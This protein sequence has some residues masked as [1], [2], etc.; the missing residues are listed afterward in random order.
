VALSV[1]LNS[2]ARFP[3]TVGINVTE[4]WQEPPTGSA[5][6]QLL[7]SEKSP[8]YEICKMLIREA[9]VLLNVTT[10]GVEIVPTT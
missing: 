7:V 2:P 8:E 9:P 3:A 6:P 5:A 4:I 1:M 10:C